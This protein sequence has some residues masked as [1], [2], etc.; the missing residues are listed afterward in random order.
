[1][2][3]HLT[4]KTI[5][6]LTKEDMYGEKK[7]GEKRGDGGNAKAGSLKEF[8]MAESEDEALHNDVPVGALASVMGLELGPSLEF[9]GVCLEKGVGV[10]LKIAKYL[11]KLTQA[12]GLDNIRTI[13][14]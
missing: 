13:D 8:S 6:A 1:M 14:V 3:H 7:R 10:A 5:S 9:D 12:I 4:G 11:C 2:I